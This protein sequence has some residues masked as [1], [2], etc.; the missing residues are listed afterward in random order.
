[1]INLLAKLK[2]LISSF[3]FK[4]VLIACLVLAVVG[5]GWLS[6]WSPN[7]VD[8]QGLLSNLEKRLTEQH[9]KEILDRDG[10][11]RELSNRLVVSDSK[12]KALQK[13]LAEVKDETIVPP[14]TNKELRDRFIALGF[15]PK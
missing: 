7:P 1:M 6:W 13:R 14:T 4:N 3:G 8:V 10:R 11:I 5:L 12:L 15:T 9:Q 2:S